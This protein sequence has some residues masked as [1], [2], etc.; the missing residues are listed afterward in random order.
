MYGR[1]LPNFF[2]QVDCKVPL[3]EVSRKILQ[4]LYM[5]P[6]KVMYVYPG[7]I[8][9]RAQWEYHDWKSRRFDPVWSTMN[10][11]TV[12]PSIS[13]SHKQQNYSPANCWHHHPQTFLLA[14]AEFLHCFSR[15]LDRH[16]SVMLTED[17]FHNLWRVCQ[18]EIETQVDRKQI[19]PFLDLQNPIS[20]FQERTCRIHFFAVVK[21]VI[22][23]RVGSDKGDLG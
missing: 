17:K 20:T 22:P 2:R 14:V 19:Y 3:K 13:E 8:Q 5:P 10:K 23:P 21:F 4:E 7:E 15:Q 18:M 6:P 16:R 1:P 12:L 9:G 11:M